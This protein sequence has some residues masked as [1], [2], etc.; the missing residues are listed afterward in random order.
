LNCRSLGSEWAGAVGEADWNVPLNPRHP[1]F[2]RIQ[3]AA[4]KP[5]RCDE[6]IFR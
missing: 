4:P 6:R 2:G 5:F 3:L 1:D